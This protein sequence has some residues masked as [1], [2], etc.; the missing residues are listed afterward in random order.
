LGGRA[1]SREGLVG[2]GVNF[3]TTYR[4]A[5]AFAD[6]IL[7]GEKAANIPTEQATEFKLVINLHAAQKLSLNVPPIL[8]AT[9]GEVIE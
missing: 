4:R 3:L 5:A 1:A 7:K 2:Y 9:A 6:K 8:L